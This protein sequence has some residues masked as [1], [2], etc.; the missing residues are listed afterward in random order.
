MPSSRKPK[1][2]SENKQ[3]TT[4]LK[5]TDNTL[6]AIEKFVNLQLCI[7]G[8]LQLVAK[9]FP[10]QVVNT[11]NFWMRTRSS[12]TPSEWTAKIALG[13]AL[14]NNYGFGKYWINEL[15]QEKQDIGN[16]SEP[17]KVSA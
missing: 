17:E 10:N 13:K 16:R 11:A 2:N 12:S 14:I 3:P 9:N 6:N 5:C 1:K 4:N 7:L 15:I 8:I